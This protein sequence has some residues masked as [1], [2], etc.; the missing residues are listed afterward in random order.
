MRSYYQPSGFFDPLRVAASIALLLPL[1]GLLAWLLSAVLAEDWY[2]T[3]IMPALAAL[4]LAFAGRG[5]CRWSHA[6]NPALGF[7]VG[8]SLATVMYVGQHYATMVAM[9]G[10]R[11]ILRIDIFPL[12]LVEAVNHLLIGDFLSHRGTPT[13]WLN[14]STFCLELAACV[15]MSGSAWYLAARQPYCEQCGRWLGSTAT[16]L[17]A[18][19]ARVL[20]AAF[21]TDAFESLP[22]LETTYGESPDCYGRL[23]VAGCMHGGE[24]DDAIIYATVAEI[25]RRDNRWET[26]NLVH[27]AALTPEELTIIYDRCPALQVEPCE[28]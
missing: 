28:A 2:L 16:P 1:A 18:G 11:A 26:K 23:E 24:G 21:H 6:R 13:P 10:P 3:V 22:T 4:P 5:L 8:A 17:R 7:V 9:L 27:Q 20:A 14:W 15:F 19:S 25:T 12:F